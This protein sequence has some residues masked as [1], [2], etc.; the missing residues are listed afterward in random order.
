[1]QKT[2]DAIRAAVGITPN[3]FRP[4][5]G[6][7]DQSVLKTTGKTVIMWSVDSLD[8]KN[9]NIQKN[10]KKTLSQ[11]HDGAIIL[12]HDIHKESVDTIPVLIDQLREQ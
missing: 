1:M 10:L 9:R 7:Y 3:L 12:F 2:D 4:P 11:V 6:A 8:W 5:Y